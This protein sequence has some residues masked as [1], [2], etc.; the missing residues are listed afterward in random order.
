MSVFLLLCGTFSLGICLFV[1]LSFIL[2]Y[3]G[4]VLRLDFY[5][6]N[7]KMFQANILSSIAEVT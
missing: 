2:P 1:S 4:F 5:Y 6:G 3:A 7:T